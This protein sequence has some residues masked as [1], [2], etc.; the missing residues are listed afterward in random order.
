MR[1]DTQF[2]LDSI[3]IIL[4]ALPVTAFISVFSMLLG[5]LLGLLIA[6]IRYYKIPV[7]DR[8][9]RVYVSLIR[10]FPL[11]VQ[12]YLAYFGL[13]FYINMYC[14]SVGIDNLAKN[15][16]PLAFAVF[17]FSVNT[18]AY[19]SEVFRSALDSLDKGQR[20]ACSSIGMTSFQT[21]AHILLPQAMVA[22]IPNLVNLF[23][24]NIKA[25][26]LAYMISVHEMM[27][28]AV[29]LANRAYNY[30]EIYIVTAV[31]YWLLCV[32]LERVF[33]RMEFRFSRYKVR[34]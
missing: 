31:I 12:L 23:L 25:S 7:L 15:I 14:Q 10:G 11:M 2:M 24:G 22:A 33:A 9:F 4:K 32:L 1:L 8:L 27:G 26:T 5:G 13:P 30:L 19:V 28:V 34:V 3:P 29:V 6:L 16:P 18:S 21:M 17:A 20:E